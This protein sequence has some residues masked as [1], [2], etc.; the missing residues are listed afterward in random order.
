[1]PS[2]ELL[3][4]ELSSADHAN[5]LGTCA[6]CTSRN[7]HHRLDRF[8]PAHTLEPPGSA[9]QREPCPSRRVDGF[10]LGKPFRTERPPVDGMIRIAAD[11][12]G[13]AILDADEHPAAD[14]AV[15]AGR[16]H[17][18]VRNLAGRRVAHHRVERVGILVGAGAEAEEAFQAH[19]ASLPR[20]GAT[21]CFGTALTKKR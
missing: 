15:A 5:G 14:G 12:D 17:P 16:W 11:A 4:D 6:V 8:V 13:A 19:A 18:A 20:Y 10:V 1:M 3:R 7:L 9:Q 21:M 2:V